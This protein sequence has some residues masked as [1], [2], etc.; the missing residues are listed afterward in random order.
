M[1]LVVSTSKV[2]A[3]SALAKQLVLEKLAA[4]VNVVE[5]VTSYYL[6]EGK[7]EQDAEALLIVKTTADAV[8]RLC[9][10]LKEIHAY[11]VPEIISVEILGDEGNR[12]YLDWV[13]ENV[14]SEKR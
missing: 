2:E 5:G 10:R 7:L 13:R 14:L 1:R 6:W 8:D 11:D 4:C 12:D 9:S 3:A